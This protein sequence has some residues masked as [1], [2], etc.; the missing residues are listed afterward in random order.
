MMNIRELIGNI[1]GAVEKLD[2]EKSL[3]LRDVPE[4]D[5]EWMRIYNLV[6]QRKNEGE[7][8][9]EELDEICEMAYMKAFD[10]REDD[11]IAAYVSDDFGLIYDAD[12]LEISD[13]WLDKLIDCYRRSVFPC[14]KL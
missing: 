2:I 1:P 14:G 7:D 5:S 12:S 11:E 9:G 4:F 3:D 10:T 8:S 6:E 13:P